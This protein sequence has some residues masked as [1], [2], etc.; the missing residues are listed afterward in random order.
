MSGNGQAR[1]W[2]VGGLALGRGRLNPENEGKNGPRV[3]VNANET[4]CQLQ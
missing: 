4:E 2:R 1:I 3:Q